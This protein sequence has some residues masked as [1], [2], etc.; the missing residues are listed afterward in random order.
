MNK[1]RKSATLILAVAASATVLSL[2]ACQGSSSGS[3]GQTTKAADTA[4][5][6]KTA[7]ATQAANAASKGKFK[8][9]KLK[10]QALGGGACGAP[11]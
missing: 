2:T 7:E 6:A 9:G 1:F 8:L 3:T 5:S 10:I 11:S 4:A